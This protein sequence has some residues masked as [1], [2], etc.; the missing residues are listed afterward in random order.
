VSKVSKASDAVIFAGKKNDLKVLL[1]KRKLPPFQNMWAFPSGPVEETTLKLSEDNI[2]PLSIRDIDGRDPRGKVISYPFLS[3]LDSEESVTPMNDA[4]EAKFIP[5]LEIEE[6]AFDHGAILCEALSK[7]YNFM[8]SHSPLL[9]I[10]I[11]PDLFVKSS[12]K[13]DLIFYGGSFNP[14][15]E[16]HSKCLDLCIE[17]ASN[18]SVIVVP[19]YSPWKS[20]TEL[21]T[22]CRYKSFLQI[23]K[24]NEERDV[25]VYPGFWGMEEVNP[26]VNWIGEVKSNSISLL[27]GADS[28]VNIYRWQDAEVLLSKLNSI[29]MV[30]RNYSQKDIKYGHTKISQINPQIEVV[31]LADHEYESVSSTEIRNRK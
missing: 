21:A 18:S 14:W 12:P 2:V 26:T 19:D 3:Y 7:F 13:S 1:V 20:T 9:D 17:K 15:H 29:Y 8:P 5:I 30:P 24:D 4:L 31:Y 25:L 11:L 27:V 23:A 6:M 22:T 28:F 16:G 10:S